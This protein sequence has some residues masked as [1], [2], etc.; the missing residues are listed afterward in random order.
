MRDWQ[1]ATTMRISGI[2]PESDKRITVVCNGAAIAAVEEG[3]NRPDL[4]SDDLYLS[5]GMIDLMVPG[6][7]GASFRNAADTV[8]L[9]RCPV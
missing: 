3:I 7:G 4:G 2:L 6:Y 9:R 1:R 8:A 5:V